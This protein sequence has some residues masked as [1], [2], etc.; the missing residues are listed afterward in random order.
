MIGV[1]GFAV[2][3]IVIPLLVNEAGELSRSLARWLLR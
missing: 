3:A 2:A 1:L